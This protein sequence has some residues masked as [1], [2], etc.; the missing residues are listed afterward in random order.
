MTVLFV[1]LHRLDDVQCTGDEAWIGEC[2]MPGWGDHN[3]IHDEDV[4]ICCQG[5]PADLF[6]QTHT[7]THTLAVKD[8][9]VSRDEHRPAVAHPKQKF[10]LDARK[11]Q[12]KVRQYE[13]SVQKPAEA[14]GI[15]H[16]LSAKAAKADL[17]AYFAEQQDRAQ[18]RRA[19][20]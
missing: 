20:S 7:S 11:M 19:V 6:K 10:P 4:G 15:K 9:D 2:E 5:C 1:C 8:K 18:A 12:H 17:D 14:T 16:G 3:C 13:A